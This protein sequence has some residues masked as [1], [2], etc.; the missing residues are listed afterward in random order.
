M[1]RFGL[2]HYLACF[3]LFDGDP[4]RVNTILDEVS[5]RHARTGASGR[6]P[7]T[8]RERRRDDRPGHRWRRRQPVSR[9]RH[10]RLRRPLAGSVPT[11]PI[12]SGRAA[13]RA[14]RRGTSRKAFAGAAGGF[15]AAPV[16]R[17]RSGCPAAMGPCGTDPSPKARFRSDVAALVPVPVEP[18]PPSNGPLP[19]PTSDAPDVPNAGEAGPAEVRNGDFGCHSHR[20]SPVP[21]VSEGAPAPTPV[22]RGPSVASPPPPTPS[23]RPTP[24]RRGAD[25]GVGPEGVDPVLV[26]LDRMLGGGLI[27]AG[28]TWSRGPRGAGRPSSGSAS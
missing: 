27:A 23:R 26:G 3:T 10:R 8:R 1:P 25:D 24:P 21:E 9:T 7:P 20:R 19:T 22:P 6:S 2:M 5:R 28:P 4:G 17:R 11:G 16:T 14:R 12:E 18:V 13:R 15:A